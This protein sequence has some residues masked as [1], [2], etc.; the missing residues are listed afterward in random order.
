MDIK[1]LHLVFINQGRE[2]D[3]LSIMA[4]EIELLNWFMDLSC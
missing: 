3:C 2:F 4:F 1:F